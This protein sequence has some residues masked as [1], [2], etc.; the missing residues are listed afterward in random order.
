MDGE[1]GTASVS[2]WRLRVRRDQTADQKN[3]KDAEQTVAGIP[4]SKK[5]PHSARP[6]RFWGGS[7]IAKH[8]TCVWN[9][10]MK[11]ENE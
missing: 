5:N 11:M 1:I 2:G 6:F 8:K 7:T 4:F 10:I 9:W 3:E